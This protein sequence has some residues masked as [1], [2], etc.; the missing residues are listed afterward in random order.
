MST[1]RATPIPQ[2]Q[3]VPAVRCGNMVFTAGMTPREDGVLMMQGQVMLSEPPE[4]YRSAAR[5]AASNALAAAVNLLHDCEEVRAALSISVFVNA[6]SGYTEHSKIADFVSAFLCEELGD[7]G[8]GSRAAVG[9]ASLPGNAP[10]EVQ[11]V[12]MVG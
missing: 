10:L 2:G 7:A 11:I 5:L 4:T 12:F 9:V 8:I 1:H 3:Y 6:E